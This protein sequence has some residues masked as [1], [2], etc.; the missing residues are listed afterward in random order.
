MTNDEF[1]EI[2]AS[3]GYYSTPDRLRFYLEEYLFRDIDFSGKS[4][5]DIGGGYGIFAF[6]A[7]INGAREVVVMEPEIEGS[8]A[9]MKKGFESLKV[10]LDKPENI[11]H[12]GETLQTYDTANRDFDVVL[13]HNSINHLD[14]DACVILHKDRDAQDTYLE[15]FARLGEITKS[16]TTFIICDCSNDNLFGDLRLRNPM[17]RSIEWHKHQAPEVWAALFEKEGFVTQSIDW[18][19]PSF[20]GKAGRLLFGNKVMA[21]M[22]S[23]HFRLVV[24]KN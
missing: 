6:F 15:I 16:G 11:S 5:I 22:W 2:V 14:E 18:T 1:Y 17:A 10:L 9:G 20:L 13:M 24:T 8:S 4:L 12:T 7:A 19:A 3:N 23:S 21:Y